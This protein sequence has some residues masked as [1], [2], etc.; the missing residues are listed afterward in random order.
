VLCPEFSAL[1]Q[2]LV[3]SCDLPAPSGTTNGLCYAPNFQHFVNCSSHP[4]TFPPRAGQLTG[5][6]YAPNFQHFVN[7]SS[8]PAT[9]PPERDN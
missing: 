4:A 8:H 6:C 3:A 9:F 1:R 5:L 2:L 7:C